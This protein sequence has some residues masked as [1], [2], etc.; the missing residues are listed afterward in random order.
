[1]IDWKIGFIKLFFWVY[2][3]LNLIYSYVKLYKNYYIERL[4]KSISLFFGEEN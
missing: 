1:M 3:L 2:K 4:L